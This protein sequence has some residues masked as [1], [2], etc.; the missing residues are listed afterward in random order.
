[1]RNIILIGLLMGLSACGVKPKEVSAPE[2]AENAQ[3]PRTYPDLSTDPA[4]EN[5]Q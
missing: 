3:F 1:M 5:Q 4:P 2:G